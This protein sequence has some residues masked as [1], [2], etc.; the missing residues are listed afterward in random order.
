MRQHQ[1]GQCVVSRTSV[2]LSHLPKQS[3][4]RRPSPNPS[5][6]RGFALTAVCQ[7][8]YALLRAAACLGCWSL[9]TKRDIV[10]HCGNTKDHG[11]LATLGA[12]DEDPEPGNGVDVTGEAPV[13]GTDPKH[14]PRKDLL[15]LR[16]IANEWRCQR[17]PLIC[18]CV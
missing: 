9:A 4:K 16:R 14:V 18:S 2:S 13:S 7:C 8:C 1:V 5:A 12:P 15:E 10:R 3:W 6:R 11:C 17:W